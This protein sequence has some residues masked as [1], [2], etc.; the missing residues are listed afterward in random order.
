MVVKLKSNFRV[1]PNTRFKTTRSI[2]LFPDILSLIHIRINY[3]MQKTEQATFF[4]FLLGNDY[5]FRNLV[6]NNYK[7]TRTVKELAR[8][9]GISLSSFKRNS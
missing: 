3:I 1:F 5:K 2:I 6:L 4:S 9:C 7:N 8:L